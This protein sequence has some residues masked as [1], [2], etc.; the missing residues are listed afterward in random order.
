MTQKPLNSRTFVTKIINHVYLFFGS[1]NLAD[2]YGHRGPSTYLLGHWKI[3]W[4]KGKK[5]YL[6]KFLQN[7]PKI[8]K[9]SI[10]RKTSI[11][12][13]L[14][15]LF[16]PFDEKWVRRPIFYLHPI[17]R[18]KNTHL[19]PKKYH[20]LKFWKNHPK[21]SYFETKLFSHVYLFFGRTNL[22]DIYGQ[23][24]PITYLLEP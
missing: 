4:K 15:T 13:T 2:I 5:G 24:G 18:Q 12:C 8:E 6:Q 3:F 10:F 21:W 9:I 14:F 7:L 23:E 22:N 1:P 19:K 11:Y 20:F 17:F 16:Y